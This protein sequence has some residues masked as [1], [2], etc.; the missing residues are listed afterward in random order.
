[1]SR[2]TIRWISGPVLRRVARGPFALREAVRVGPQAL[3]GEVVRIDR[4]EIVVQVYEDTTGLRP[5][6]EVDGT[7]LPLAIPLGPGLLGNI[8]DG[9]LR[10]LSGNRLGVRAARD[11]SRRRRRRSR[12]CRASRGR[13]AARPA[14]SSAQATANARPRASGALRRPTPAGEVQRVVA[15][16]DY[17]EDAVVCTVRGA[18]GATRELVDAPRRG[19]CACRAR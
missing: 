18:D 14:R 10:P 4:D 12:S 3:L 2:A 11:A 17:R 16:G 5:G 6:T 7:G 15:A 13:R 19:R 9:L 8:F 1:M